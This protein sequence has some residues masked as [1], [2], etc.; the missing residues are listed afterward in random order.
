MPQPAIPVL[1]ATEP[2]ADGPIAEHNSLTRLQS[3]TTDV[4]SPNAPLHN[5][6]LYRKQIAG[7]GAQKSNKMTMPILRLRSQ[8]KLDTIGT[9][10]RT[11]YPVLYG[12]VLGQAA[13][14]AQS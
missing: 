1:P 8:R 14:T 4:P 5:G 2:I 7:S 11:G 3:P 9:I 10:A 12:A 13:R 6:L